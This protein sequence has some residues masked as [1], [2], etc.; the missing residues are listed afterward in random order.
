MRLKMEKEIIREMEGEMFRE[1]RKKKNAITADAAESLLKRA[2]AV[3][4]R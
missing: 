3:F 2:D 4:S 1:I